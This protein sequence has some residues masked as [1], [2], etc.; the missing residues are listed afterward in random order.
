MQRSFQ[1]IKGW[2]LLGIALLVTGSGLPAIGQVVKRLPG[3]VPR[4]EAIE[5]SPVKDQINKFI[6]DTAKVLAAGEND[7]AVRDAREALA[8]PTRNPVCSPAFMAYYPFQVV[9]A[10]KGALSH[11]RPSVRMNALIVL[12]DLRSKVVAEPALKALADKHPGCRYWAAKVLADVGAIGGALADSIYDLNQQKAILAALKTAMPIE[13][14]PQALEQMY[15]AIS[16]LRLPEADETLLKVL[17]TRLSLHIKAID[18]SIQADLAGLNVYKG[19]LVRA[20]AEGKVNIDAQARNL[21]A[22][23][24]KYLLV[25]ATALQ[26][27]K[28]GADLNQVVMDV[29]VACEEV[30]SDLAAKRFDPGM[31]KPPLAKAGGNDALLLNTLDWVGDGGKP[32]LLTSSKIAIPA[33]QLKLPAAK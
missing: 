29:I 12:D 11:A 23:A 1:V 14:Q 28:V 26:G 21:T 27:G 17:D 25:C 6:A 8:D 2:T 22:I 10:L 32:G 20:D 19:K 24:A 3:E 30:L 4:A 9:A 33:A 13:K 16:A 31:K 18:E 5:G 7:R 15:R